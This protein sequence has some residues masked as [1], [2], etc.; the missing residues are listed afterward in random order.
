[1]PRSSK[2]FVKRRAGRQIR[3]PT[4]NLAKGG[5]ART[6]EIELFQS[7]IYD[8][9][10]AMAKVPADAVDREIEAWLGKISLALDLDRSA[11]YERDAPGQ[12]V[13]T[14]HTWLRPD[15]PPFPRRYDPEK[16]LKKTTAWVMAGNLLIFSHPSE[17]PFDLGD[18]RQFVER[19]GP[20]A[21]AILP[22]WAGGGVIGAASFGRFRSPREWNPKV[23]EQLAFAVRIFGGAIERKQAEAAGRVTRTELALAQR[24]SMM[25]EMVASLAH[26]LNQ[27]LGAIL[28]NLGGLARL[29]SQGNPDPALAARA[30]A[31]AIEDTKR[32]GEVVRRV[33]AMFKGDA[34][35]K[36]ALDIENL[37]DEVVTLI[38]SEAALR[39]INVGIE[40]KASVARVVGDRVLLQQCILNLLM[41]AFDA[42][43]SLDRDRRTVTINVAPDEQN[44]IAIS[45]RDAGAGIHPSVAGRLFE[46]FVTTKSNGMGLG[47]LV[48]R[49]I[50]EEHGGKVLSQPNPEGGTT[51]T[52]TLPTSEKKNRKGTRRS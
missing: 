31:N 34:T 14:S 11:I 38:A 5:T 10:A 24:R 43:A 9:S 12:Q 52:L 25:G 26:E 48:T 3:P 21:S 8:L 32:A 33:R 16:V 40:C 36:I 19:Y 45:V 37:V 35:H 13:R 27:P 2:S 23:L 49:S 28:S 18:G 42:V 7:V 44:W 15:F 6:H 17:I 51:F 46:P 30:V 4:H 41:N 22:M 1:M 50:I 20:K 39:E 29:V 47:L